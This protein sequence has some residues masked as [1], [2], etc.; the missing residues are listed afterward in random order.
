M[1]AMN[2][3]ND[4]DGLQEGLN[5][6][7]GPIC[8][9][10][11]QEAHVLDDAPRTLNQFLGLEG[12]LGMVH[13]PQM[14]R[15]FGDKRGLAFGRRSQKD[16]NELLEEVPLQAVVHELCSPAKQ[17][18]GLHCKSDLELAVGF[19]GNGRQ[20][21]APGADVRAQI[22]QHR[23]RVGAALTE[24]L[25]EG[26]RLLEFH[27]ERGIRGHVVR[28]LGLVGPQSVRPALV[29]DLV[30]RADVAAKADKIVQVEAQLAR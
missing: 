5:V 14:C 9:V 1:P 10:S 2:I 20:E 18:D 25:V 24:L 21:Q 6:G 26:L 3:G 13:L 28:L 15:Q 22:G 12:L 30:P 11:G 19:V 23:A 17:D 4:P 7:L 8:Q 27:W 29:P 16:Q